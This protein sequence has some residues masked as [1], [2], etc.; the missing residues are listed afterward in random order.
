MHRHAVRARR[1]RT[2]TVAILFDCGTRVGADHHA[3]GCSCRASDMIF[4]VA[5]GTAIA[6]GRRDGGLPPNEFHASCS[7][8][9]LSACG[10]GRWIRV[11][12]AHAGS[13]RRKR[14][15]TDGV[16]GP[17]IRSSR[18]FHFALR[19]V[20]RF[21]GRRRRTCVCIAQPTSPKLPRY[22]LAGGRHGR[23]HRAD[24]RRRRRCRRK[25]PRDAGQSRPQWPRGR[26]AGPSSAHPYVPIAPLFTSLR[27]GAA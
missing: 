27:S 19:V 2:A 21:H 15:G 11:P 24:H 4:A 3:R 23:T 25:E 5:D 9:F 20:P 22:G 17:C 1:R 18:N 26:R 6:F 16:S 8:R 7:D 12:Q 13:A 14:A 10:P